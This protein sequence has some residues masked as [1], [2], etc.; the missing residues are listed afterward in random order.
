MSIKLILIM[1]VVALIAVG[2]AYWVGHSMGRSSGD[3]ACAMA[4]AGDATT[5]AARESKAQQL[6]RQ[7]QAQADQQQIDDLK[8][9]LGKAQEAAATAA[10][11]AAEAQARSKQLNSTLTELTHEDADVHK[12]DGHCLPPALLARLHPEAGPKEYPAACRAAGDGHAG[13]VPAAAGKAIA[14]H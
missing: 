7:A 6:A 13:A 8:V 14:S 1:L 3:V 9:L 5:Y 12:W 2:V 4:H 11:T 10:A